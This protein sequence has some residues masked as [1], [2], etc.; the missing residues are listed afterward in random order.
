MLKIKTEVRA[1]CK[2]HP[3]YDPA[4]DGAGGIKDNCETCSALLEF[5][6]VATKFEES[7]ASFIAG[8]SIR[9]VTHRYVAD[10]GARFAGSARFQYRE[11]A[12]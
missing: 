2:R 3:G 5:C 6:I 7:A 8:S 1:K 4:K 12:A 11:R 9:N 10:C